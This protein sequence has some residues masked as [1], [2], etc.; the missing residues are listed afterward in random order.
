MC[1]FIGGSGHHLDLRRG[2]PWL[3]RRGPD[4]QRVWTSAD[5]GVSLLH[6]RLAIVDRDARAHQ[7]LQNQEAGV[8]V[9]L[10][11]EIYNYEQ[12]KTDLSAYPFVTQSD[13]EVVLAAYVQNGVDGFALLKGMFA[14]V[15]IDERKRCI[16]LLRDAIGKKPL[17]VAQ[18]GG[19]VL[20]GSSLLPLVAVYGCRPEI[21]TEILSHYWEQAYIPPWRS[22]FRGIKP[23]LP[24]ELLTLDWEGR[25]VRTQRCEPVAELLYAGESASEAGRNVSALLC[26]AVSRRLQNNPHPTLLLSGGIDST[27]VT[28]ATAA[29]HH[30]QGDT[31]PLQ[32]ITLGAVIPGTQD[33]GYARYAAWRLGVPLT[34][35]RS[36]QSGRLSE[37]VLRAL[38]TQDEP[39][40]MPSYFLL[41]RLVEVAARY[42]RVLLTG[43]GGDE[44]FLGYGAPAAWY[45]STPAETEEEMVLRVGRGPSAWMSPWARQVT[46]STLVGHMFAKVDRASAEQGVELR[47]PLLDWDVVCYVRSL[48]F[49]ILTAGNRTKA[50]L[51]DQLAGWP[52]WF[53]ERRKIGF[54]FNLR[55]MWLLSRFDQLREHIDPRAIETFAPFLA[56]VMRQPPRTWKNRDILRNFS[57]TWRL[58][59]WSAFLR[60]YDKAAGTA[61]LHAGAP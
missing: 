26:Q 5:G 20:F 6:A 41:H 16:F 19:Q 40:G 37:H 23:V 58:L 48:P 29:L 13:T 54:A 39:L 27:V 17:Y 60:R 11:G 7:P 28:A 43:D 45:G 47:C 59:A 33:E 10:A 22:V 57:T 15:V 31:A 30:K 1:G 38:E 35:M 52:R 14:L 42:S 53:I 44:V 46:G 55:W 12:L 8:T 51:K 32:T 24:G 25:T 36:H 2:L 4:S 9:A 3:G 21:D 49:E 34:I 61:D 18:W 56:P 50:L